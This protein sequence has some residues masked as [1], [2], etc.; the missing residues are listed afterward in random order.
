MW[1][2]ETRA[3]AEIASIKS[4][5]KRDSKNSSRSSEE[6]WISGNDVG[7]PNPNNWIHVKE[8]DEIHSC[9]KIQE[10]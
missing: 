6:S 1:K 2:E 9:R 4:T 7:N 8:I 5:E 3:A 10:K